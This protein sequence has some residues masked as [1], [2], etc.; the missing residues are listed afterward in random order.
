MRLELHLELCLMRL[1]VR[2]KHFPVRLERRLEHHPARQEPV[3]ELPAQTRGCRP[4]T[5]MLTLVKDPLP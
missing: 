1:E 2:V 3:L 4:V 5:V